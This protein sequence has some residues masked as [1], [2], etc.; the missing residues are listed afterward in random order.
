MPR[1][2]FGIVC[3]FICIALVNAYVVYAALSSQRGVVSSQPYEDGL[4]YQDTI[5]RLQA[6]RGLGWR[7]KL[8]LSEA[9]S[10]ELLLHDK[11]GLPIEE[12]EIEVKLLR[13]A[14]ASL[15]TSVTLVPSA[16]GVYAEPNTPS[17]VPGLYLA[18]IVARKGA[19]RFLEKKQFLAT[20]PAPS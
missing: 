11:D 16:P 14:D 8:N 12:A 3:F 13:P 4:A 6:S 18:E 1:W 10:L 19:D 5:D 2:V 20:R 7:T 9:G 17:I 15:D